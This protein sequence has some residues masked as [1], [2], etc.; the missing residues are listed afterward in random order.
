VDMTYRPF[1]AAAPG[2]VPLAQAYVSWVE[3]I[4]LQ[5]TALSF[6]DRLVEPLQ[7]ERYW[8]IRQLHEPQLGPW[9]LFRLRSIGRPAGS[10][11]SR[12]TSRA[13]SR[14]R[15]MCPVRVREF[16]RSRH[17]P[18]G[19]GPG[20]DDRLGLGIPRPRSDRRAHVSANDWCLG[21]GSSLVSMVERS[22]RQKVAS[23]WH[24]WTG[25]GWSERLLGCSLPAHR[26]DAS[27]AS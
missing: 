14:K 26:K 20:L 19:P 4:E 22:A 27:P 18:R 5:F 11:R 10:G 21:G 24:C 9:R 23:D 1:A 16:G 25:S 13:V 17:R 6:D 12:M 7:T 15:E 2:A 8:R 3:S